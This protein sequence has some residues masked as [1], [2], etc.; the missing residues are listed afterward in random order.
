VE[1]PELG[2]LLVDQLVG[3]VHVLVREADVE[4][5]RLADGADAVALDASRRSRG[6]ASKAGPGT[7]ADALMGL[8]TAGGMLAGHTIAIYIASTM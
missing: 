5:E 1:Q 7:G 2:V 4:L 3:D 8:L 6:R